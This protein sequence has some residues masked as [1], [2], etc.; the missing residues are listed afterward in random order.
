M[1]KF[2]SR[3]CGGVVHSY[4]GTLADA[5]ELIELGLHIGVNGCSLKTE[6]NLEVVRNLPLESILLE[7]D[8]PWCGIKSTH[9]S[10]SLA[11]LQ[12]DSWAIA[13]KPER[14]A[15]G[16]CVKDRCE[17]CHIVQVARVVAALHDVPLDVVADTTTATAASLFRLHV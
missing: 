6:E 13:K 15:A 4:T 2:R 3:F 8:A 9:A 12:S 17:P 11:D 14:K 7:T 5:R 16:E 10:S 1:R